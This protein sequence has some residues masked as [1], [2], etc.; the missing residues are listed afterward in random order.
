MVAAAARSAPPCRPSARTLRAR[1]RVQA[2]RARISSGEVASS[3]PFNRASISS[4]LLDALAAGAGGDGAG[5][6]TAPR[7]FRR[8]DRRRNLRRWNVGHRRLRS[9]RGGGAASAGFGGSRRGAAAAAGAA[10]LLSA[11]GG[12]ASSSAMIRRI[13]ARISSIEGSWTFAGCVI[14]DSTSSTPSHALSYTK[15]DGMGRLRIRGLARFPSQARLVPRSSRHDVQR[16]RSAP[17]R[18]SKRRGHAACAPR[19][20]W[21][22]SVKAMSWQLTIA[23]NGPRNGFNSHC[24]LLREAFQQALALDAPRGE[25]HRPPRAPNVS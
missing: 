12:L 8:G 17:L 5:G 2:A 23:S 22:P 9:R 7:F 13:D 24:D 11:A 18:A 15:H 21:L 6:G 4:W 10:G 14:S 3:S 1:A 16:T 19:I 25:G 20:A